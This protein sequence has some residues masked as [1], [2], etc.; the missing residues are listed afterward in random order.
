VKEEDTAHLRAVVPNKKKES[1]N[2]M[3][4]AVNVDLSYTRRTN[5][6]WPVKMK[7]KLMLN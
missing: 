5:I 4:A 7:T 6:E 2:D 3:L 1:L